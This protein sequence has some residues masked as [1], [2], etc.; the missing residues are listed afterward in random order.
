M[1][2]LIEFLNWQPMG[3]QFLRVI[4]FI[5]VATILVLINLNAQYRKEQR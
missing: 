3:D 4:H 1:T 5:G 2:A